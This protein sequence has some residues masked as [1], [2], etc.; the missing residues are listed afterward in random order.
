MY[1]PPSD[2]KRAGGEPD[3]PSP[4]RPRYSGVSRKPGPKPREAFY[5]DEH[6]EIPRIR[7]AS[8]KQAR[9]EKFPVSEHGLGDGNQVNSPSRET[10]SH[11]RLSSRRKRSRMLP[12]SEHDLADDN[13]IS[14]PRREIGSREEQTSKQRR[15]EMLPFTGLETYDESSS[16]VAAQEMGARSSRSTRE[17]SLR[18]TGMQRVVGGPAHRRYGKAPFGDAGKAGC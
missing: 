10:D 1:K 17:S 5:A 18:T 12:I 15:A 7:R 6:P 3:N 8:L 2:D 11:S 16:D 4:K 13:P 14:P 9:V